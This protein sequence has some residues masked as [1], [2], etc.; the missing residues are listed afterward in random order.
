MYSPKLCGKQC[1]AYFPFLLLNVNLNKFESTEE[2]D[3]IASHR[4]VKHSFCVMYVRFC[5]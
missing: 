5:T 4:L 3:V 2:S 1:L